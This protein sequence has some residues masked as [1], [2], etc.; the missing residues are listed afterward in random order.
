M[1]TPKHGYDR[2]Q[3]FEASARL[4]KALTEYNVPHEYI[5]CEHSGHGLQNDN[6]EFHMY[7]Q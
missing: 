4:D 6:K 5:V 1:L 7:N 3:S 2:V